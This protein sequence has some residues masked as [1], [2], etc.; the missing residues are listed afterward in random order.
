MLQENRS[1][2]NLQ[3]QIDEEEVSADLILQG[4]IYEQMYKLPALIFRQRE[5]TQL[6]V[7]LNNP[8]F[9]LDSFAAI[10]QHIVSTQ[11]P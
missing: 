1:K 4:L 11:P 10:R 9:Q 6:N 7:E 5:S 2:D 3:R 8:R